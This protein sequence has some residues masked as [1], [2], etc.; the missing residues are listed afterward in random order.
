MKILFSGKFPVQAWHGYIWDV[1]FNRT[2]GYGFR[3]QRNGLLGV[4]ELDHIVLGFGC[5]TA[6]VDLEIKLYEERPVLEDKWEEVVEASFFV[7]SSLDAINAASVASHVG[8]SG[9]QF[10][11]WAFLGGLVGEFCIPE[12]SYRLRYCAQNFGA[13]EFDD[14]EFPDQHEYYELCF[15]PAPIGSDE[16]IRVTKDRARWRHESQQ[17]DAE[18]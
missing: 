9:V 3:G 6:P 7:R 18:N 8:G 17:K 11:L 2:P 4:A 15:W 10:M 12:G 1:D 16:I 5:H 14:E 13:L